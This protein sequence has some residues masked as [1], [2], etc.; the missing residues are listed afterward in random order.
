VFKDRRLSGDA[1]E[2]VV[3]DLVH[4]AVRILTDINDDPAHLFAHRGTL[5][6]DPPPRINDFRDHVNALF[7]K[8]GAPF[9]LH[10]GDQPWA[11]TSRQFRR[12]LSA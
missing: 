11:F 5:M 1:A 6:D 10:D 9:I 7:G 12:I 3:L 2:W 8:D 4:Q